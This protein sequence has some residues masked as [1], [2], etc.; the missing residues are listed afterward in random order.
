MKDRIKIVSASAGSG[1]TTR[2]ARELEEAVTRHGIAP[3]RI[4]A[5]TFTKKAAAELIE[6]GRRALL[7]AGCPAE[8]E[9]F[10]TA[11]IGTVNA[12]AGMIV[13]DFA[14]EAGIS[15]ELIVLDETR[16]QEAFRK[17]LGQVVT[18]DDLAE[19][20]R[21]A[22]CFDDLDW[23]TTVRQIADAARQNHLGLDGLDA[24]AEA[25]VRGFFELLDEPTEPAA[26]LD[27]RLATTLTGA[28]A[29]LRL[30]LA[31]GADATKQSA[32]TL[33]LYE[34]ALH[35][36]TLQGTLPWPAWGRLTSQ[37]AATK[38]DPPC[39]EVRRA[40]RALLAHPQLREDCEVA[41]RLHFDLARR[42]L[43][44]YQRWKTARRAID[45]VDQETL[46]LE[47]LQR[48]DVRGVLAR[49]TSLVLV[50]EFQDVSP[51]QLALFLALAGLAP[52]SVWVG[53][54]KQAIY[55]FRGADPALMEAVV[56]ELLGGEEPETLNVGRRSRAPL[57]RLTNALFVPPFAAAGLPAA[58][59][60]LDPTVPEDRAR[61]GPAVER[62]PLEARRKPEAT[63]E[64]ARTVRALL[65][66]DSVQVRDRDDGTPRRLRPDD[67]AILCRRGDTCL[68]LATAL[69][70]LGV[71]G[72][73]ARIGLLATPE[74]RAV[75]AGLRLWVDAA[76][77][78][79]RAEIAH[80]LDPGSVGID[81]LLRGEDD[82]RWGDLEPIARL[83]AARGAAP[84]AGALDAFDAVLAALHLDDLVARW[85]RGGQGLA[86]LDALRAQAVSF[87]RLA[88]HHAGGSSPAALLAHLQSLAADANDPQ[89]M[90][91]R[92]DAVEIVTWHAAKGLEWPVVVLYELDSE[93]PSRALGV[94]VDDRRG[95]LPR[96]DA[97]LEGR[98]IRYWPSPFPA[99]ASRTPFHE[100]LRAHAVT[101]DLDDHDTREEVRLL[102]VGWTRARDRLVLAG[103]DL[104]SG[105]L[106]LFARGG[107]AGLT[108]P[109]SPAP[110][111][112]VFETQVTWGGQDLTV[113]VR[114]APPPVSA[115]PKGAGSAEVLVR[116]GPRDHPP[117]RL[118][119]SEIA[120]RGRVARV[121][122]LGP[123]IT[124]HGEVDPIALG[125]AVHAFLAADRAELDADDQ[126]ELGARILDGWG[127][128]QALELEDLLEMSQRFSRWL[129]ARWPGGRARRE[130]PVE[131]RLPGGTLVRGLVD[132]ML[133]TASAVAVIDHKVIVADEA[134]AI[135]EAAGYAGQL[136]AYGEALVAAGAPGE[137]ETLIHL[138][139]A[140]LVAHLV[141]T[142]RAPP[143]PSSPGT[144]PPAPPAGTAETSTAPPA[145]TPP[146]ASSRPP[147]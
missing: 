79:A 122:R 38:S 59:V 106:A 46:A 2:L 92:D 41:I 76:D 82:S 146:R 143:P 20:T 101:A 99:N 49:E 141:T 105:M 42:A 64:L 90:A 145:R 102:Y 100:R 123:P 70:E 91:D 35:R 12:V 60:T 103:R 40:A 96:L 62:W 137:V 32:D 71:R 118:R 53:D 116:A 127:V 83:L 56:A 126:R 25:S 121:E 142:V 135:D 129:T 139:L 27:A 85:D 61:L 8:A 95:A 44:A 87:V 77:M 23:P 134:H 72:R 63:L 144:S 136:D 34:A 10:R 117:A 58:R 45:F 75:S 18:P 88:R 68:A 22:G 128:A 104:V 13:T 66:D 74:G 33:A 69:A 17:S 21:L 81:A 132:V 80:L 112:S 36:L 108:E 55:G 67:V 84:H 93:F 50:D 7:E 37:Q 14:F 57:V 78:L 39:A 4:V 86:N 125:S 111:A 9:L 133:E 107:G 3:D 5:T 51:L 28:S 47:L 19:L 65:E 147:P 115:A 73:V 89:A 52:R 26:I 130:W 43:A 98:T 48:E 31:S 131:H 119:P 138:P 29:A 54:Q 16:A 110:G 124:V 113:A 140:G 114:R 24:A 30:R 11:R 94:H 109:P 15:P 1:K 6:R 120:R 97:P